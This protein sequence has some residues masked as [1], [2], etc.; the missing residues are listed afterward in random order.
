MHVVVL[1][2]PRSGTTLVANLL[3]SQPNCTV[4][5][6]FLSAPLYAAK[7]VGGFDRVLDPRMRNRVMGQI[8]P[9]VT[10][11]ECS[12]PTLLG[13]YMAALQAIAREGDTVVGHKVVGEFALTE[14]VLT[15][16]DVRVIYVLRDVR[17]VVLSH[18]EFGWDN[19]DAA[20]ERWRQAA[21]AV[22]RIEQHPRVAIIRFE[23]LIRCP[24]AELEP[25]E[26]LLGFPINVDLPQLRS[27]SADPRWHH[28]S[29]FHDLKGLFDRQAVER[30]RQHATTPLVRYAT[31]ACRRELAAGGYDCAPLAELSP[32]ERLKFAIRATVLEAASR[33]AGLRGSLR[34]K[35]I[36]SITA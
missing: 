10:G 5:H 7:T 13:I 9:D 34:R 14:P 18:W 28:N 8:Q 26:K 17:D 23:K 22:S 30:W 19:I 4:Y 36:P 24:H 1:G 12:A 15:T 31:F 33:A 21:A 11:F 27:R 35:L 2:L 3:N 20:I 25:V 16:T 29:S 6:D 32:R